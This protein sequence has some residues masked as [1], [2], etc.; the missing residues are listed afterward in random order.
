MYQQNF[1]PTGSLLLSALLAALP[2]A[3]VLVLLGVL[4]WK[5]HWAGLAALAVGLVVAV[6]AY[7]MPVGQALDAGLFGAARSILL[8][9]WITFN[10]IWIYNLTVKSGHF[11]V[12][13]RAFSG[14]S[15]D[16]RIQAIVIA[17]C[18]GALIEALAGGGSP[19]AICA[20]M[21]IAVGFDPLK[22]AALALVAN[23]A[24]V[25]FGGMGNP[26]TILGGAPINLD[27]E[28]VGAM[29]GRQTAF[30]AIFVPFILLFIADGRRGLRQA[31]PAALVAGLSFGATQI[32]VSSAFDYRLTD[33]AASLVSAVVLIVFGKLWRPSERV[34]PVPTI[35]GGSVDD[36]AFVRKHGSPAGDTRADR[37]LAF[38][39]YAII[40][41]LFSLSVIEPIKTWLS[42]GWRTYKFLWPGAHIAKP[43]G[44]GLKVEYVLNW[45]S[46]PG[47]LL[48]IS[49][50]LTFLVLRIGVGTAIK[51]YG[52]TLRQFGWAIVTILAVFAL[53]FVMQYSGQIQT[54]GLFLAGAG[55]FFAFL[56]PVVGWFGVA[57]T[58]T[59]AGSNALFGVLQTTA[60]GKL[61]ESPILFGAANSSG[62]VMAKMISPQ[63]LA[64]GAAAVGIVGKEGEMFRRVV[65]WS[66][67]LL[68]GL[69]VIVYLES[70]PVL[71]WLVP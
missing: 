33:I 32:F 46:A 22:A 34:L 20:I 55:A 50:I 49:G 53:A 57:I 21:L 11:A 30:I 2:L 71:G 69:C 44:D 23:T 39:P 35:A 24:P 36:P 64:I 17:F 4:K 62:G 14:I 3:T 6:A 59:D 10:A 16:Q 8:I 31:W 38:A 37:I 28:Q 41:V 1:N 60:A 12:L 5:A 42:S 40:I 15:D 63:S 51:T 9:L 29:A 43:N 48:F 45:A 26:I 19:I 52:E 65:G 66:A 18:F 56:S 27:P 25:A 70:T 58:G 54:L 47:T 13:Q 68:L 61:G 7:K 67:L